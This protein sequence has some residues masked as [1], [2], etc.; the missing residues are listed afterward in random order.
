MGCLDQNATNYNADATDKDMINTAIFSVYA[1]SCDDVPG[2][3]CIYADG[4]GYFN[5][6]FGP[7]LCVTYGGTPCGGGCD[8]IDNDGMACYED[9]VLPSSFRCSLY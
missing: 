5:D 7:D 9:S 2:D 6:E 1:A 8:D 3:G 4:F